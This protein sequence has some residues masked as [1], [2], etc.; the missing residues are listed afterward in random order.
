MKEGDLVREC[1]QV[2]LDAELVHWR[3][4]SGSFQTKKGGWFRTGVKGLA[5]LCAILPPDGRL[6]MVECKTVDGRLSPDQERFLDVAG[7][8]G[9]FCVVVRDARSLAWVIGEL[10]K[11]PA[12]KAE[13]L[14]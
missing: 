2:L 11:R 6:L 9:A 10:K 8:Q 1:R 14:F 4:Q 13:D 5:D 12:M 3:S 7:R